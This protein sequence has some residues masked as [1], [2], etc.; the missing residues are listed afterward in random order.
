[1]KNKQRFIRETEGR[2]ESQQ[3]QEDNAKAKRHKRGGR[4]NRELCLCLETRECKS[5]VVGVWN[6]KPDQEILFNGCMNASNIIT[7]LTAYY[8]LYCYSS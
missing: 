5:K 8:M 7:L 2:G 6:E 1:M 4:A 3:G